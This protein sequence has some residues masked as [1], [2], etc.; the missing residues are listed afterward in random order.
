MINIFAKYKHISK[1][2]K[3]SLWFV[4]SNVMLKGI[5]FVTLPIFSR[6]LTT[7]EYGIVSVY[8]SWVSLVSIVT[9][10]TVWGGVFNVGMVKHSDDRN[11]II[12]SFQGLASTITIIFLVISVIGFNY[13]SR[14]LGISEFLMVCM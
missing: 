8:T 9:T 13:V 11:T 5:S 14:L 12:S 6:L 3:A 10:L 2:V 7:S 1:P 4:I